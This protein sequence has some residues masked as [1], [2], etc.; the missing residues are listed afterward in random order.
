MSVLAEALVTLPANRSGVALDRELS[1]VLSSN[2]LAIL[3]LV[4]EGHS[5]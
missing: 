2:Q 1:E 5:I 4:A 3:K